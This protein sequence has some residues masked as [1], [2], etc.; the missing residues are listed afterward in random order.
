MAQWPST[1]IV[2][3]RRSAPQ[4]WMAVGALA[5]LALLLAPNNVGV[6]Y[7][8]SEVPSRLVLIQ[9]CKGA[10]TAPICRGGS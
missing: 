4:G 5:T 3:V 9:M 2:D 7:A 1:S 10:H 6:L 8:E